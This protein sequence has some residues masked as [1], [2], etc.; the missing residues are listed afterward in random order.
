[1]KPMATMTSYEAVIDS[2][3]WIEYFRGS[4]SGEKAKEYIES[5]SAATS[6]ITLAELQEK[7]LREKW[8]SMEPDLKFI[9]TRTSL[10]T[11]DQKISLLAGRINY[12]NKRKINKNWGMADSIVL[13]T[14]RTFSAK[15]VTGDP[16]FKDLNDAIMIMK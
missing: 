13:A 8:D 12:E 9:T 3:A 2:Y 15:V 4:S 10:V 16:H 11:I 14:A 1:M 6:A 5:G 7:Y